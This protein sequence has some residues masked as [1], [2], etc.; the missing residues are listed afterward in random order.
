MSV[1]VIPTVAQGDCA[2]DT[3][4]FWAGGA[5]DLGT[6]KRLRQEIAQAVADHAL[7]PEWQSA[8]QCCGEYDSP[9]AEDAQSGTSALAGASRTS[10]QA[11]T[12]ALA[13]ASRDSRPVPVAVVDAVRWAMV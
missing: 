5:R 13:G 2:F 6:W 9:K 7:D 11:V 12:S 10:K 8:F 4:A 1:T 3:M